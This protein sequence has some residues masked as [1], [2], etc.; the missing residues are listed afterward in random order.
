MTAVTAQTRSMLFA[1]VATVVSVG[2]FMLAAG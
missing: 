2:G 1:L